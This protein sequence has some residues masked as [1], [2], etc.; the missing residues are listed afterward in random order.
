MKIR[1]KFINESA[2]KIPK[3][4]DYWKNK[5]KIGKNVIIHF[6]DDLDGIY[7]AIVMK[8]YLENNGFIIEAYNV[9]NYQESW[10][11][12]KINTKYINIA[13]D[14]AE[15][16]KDE[17]GTPLIDVYIDHHG[18]FD[19]DTESKNA[20][21]KTLTSSAYE[22]I[23]DQL[24]LPVD[25]M[26]L[27]I[28]DMVD[29]AKYDDYN[30]DIKNIL[31]F[32][33]SKFKNK[34]EFAASFNQ[35]LKRS[36]HKTFIEVVANS[37]DI[38]PSIYNIYKLFRLL[39]PA[40]NLNNSQLKKYAKYNGYLDIKSYI[41][42]IKKQNS[43]YLKQFEN[44]FLKDAEWRLNQMTL[45]TEGNPKKIYINSQSK[46]KQLFY[47]GKKVQ[48][49]GYQIIGNM[50]FV[51]SG[52]WANALRARS[53][54]EK[55]LLDDDRIPIINYEIQ[56]D[57]LIYTDLLESDGKRLEL[58]GDIY[59]KKF[60]VISDVTNIDNI[61]G[62]KGIIY[63]ENGKII[64]KAKQPI[65]WIMLQYGNTLQIASLHKL[66]NY[67]ER[68]LP[69]L[70]NGETVNNLG[71]YCENLLKN[72]IE[73]FGY[74]VNL[75]ENVTTLAGGHT[76]IGTISNIFGE[77]DDRV[78]SVPDPK[79]HKI[80]KLSDIAHVLMKNYNGVKFLDLIK[81]KIIDDLSGIDFKDL[82]M[83][84]GDQ[85]ERISNNKEDGWNKKMMVRDQIRK[86]KDFKIIENQYIKDFDNFK[87]II[88]NYDLTNLS[89]IDEFIYNSKNIDLYGSSDKNDNNYIKPYEKRKI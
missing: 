45:R 48:L 22:G 25:S 27:N 67:V 82:K 71:K 83:R 88:K 6:H 76:G 89:K 56:E 20:S 4:G 70:K 9:V 78:I 81:N 52:T 69:K 21:V 3:S 58:V 38:N 59:D 35:L 55:S 8:N 43:L 60:K 61:E 29:S 66:E 72:I 40:N 12:V 46:F 36:D 51:P 49:P 84:W 79:E 54:L 44:D 18:R 65:F 24:G 87:M 23:M 47:N 73:K 16:L 68:Y 64:F 19:D 42:A 77:V 34:L 13:L 41:D 74:N 57:S 11:R 2:P 75:V 33:I 80:I 86:V 1:Y 28:I 50:C 30:V 10:N 26:I 31:D 17:A 32:N 7:S 39:Y 53:I 14:Y 63:I 62:I 5:G 85:D 15:N 37:N